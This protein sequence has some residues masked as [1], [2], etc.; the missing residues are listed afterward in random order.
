ME[1]KDLVFQI[2]ALAD[3]FYGVSIKKSWPVAYEMAC[4]N[5]VKFP[6]SW[7][8]NQMAGYDWYAGF[9]QRHKLSVRTPEATSMTR[10]TAF[11]KT[12][13]EEFFNN[14]VQV[15]DKHKFPADRM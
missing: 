13:A 1:K 5:R 6:T 12:I 15:M 3:R 10:A 4:E 8:K 14:L 11:N 7:Q 9:N 2:T